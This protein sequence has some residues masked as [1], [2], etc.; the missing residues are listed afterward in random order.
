MP[1]NAAMARGRKLFVMSGYLVLVAGFVAI[2]LIPHLRKASAV[3]AGIE[4]E[5][6]EIS[7][8]LSAKRELDEITQK[9]QL[10]NM[11]VGNHDRLLPVNQDLGP[12][13]EDLSK[14][15]D[16]AGM[17]DSSTVRALP[18]MTLGKSQQLPIEVTG[19]C[20]F[21]QFHDFLVRIEHL[22]RL[23]SVSH[24]SVEADTPMT[25]KVAVQLTLSIY[26]TKPG[27]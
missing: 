12:F 16:S 1:A 18:S 27:S 8:R 5:Q 17:K 26:N 13:M 25:G 7:S 10:I 3:E 22:P 4:N 23:S 15:L 14:E 9:V 6:R 20:T 19:T 11:Q 2:G 21:S 24:L